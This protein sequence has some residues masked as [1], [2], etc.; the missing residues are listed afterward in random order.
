[1]EKNIP[2]KNKEDALSKLKGIKDITTTRKYPFLGFS[3]SLI[4]YFLLIG[5][6]IPSKSEVAFN[7]L[8]TQ[9][10]PHSETKESR[11]FKDDLDK[12]INF[13]SLI[14]HTD[15]RPVVLNCI[16]NDFTNA[17]LDEEII[18]KRFFPSDLVPIYY[19][20]NKR[21]RTELTIQNAIFFFESE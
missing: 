15:M 21:E 20:L 13:P 1:M 10:Q 6:D 8:A 11:T 18:I 12:E 3:P 2:N 19:E 14:F 4:D 9:N 7:F 5:Y 16:G 17:A